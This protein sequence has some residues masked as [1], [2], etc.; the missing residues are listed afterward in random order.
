MALDR[1]DIQYAV[2]EAC[3]GMVSPTTGDRGKLKRIARYL[4]DKPSVVWA[5]DYQERQTTIFGY[6]D[7]DWAGCRMTATSTI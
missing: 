2:K 1:S 6:S 5:C 4:C 3:R 7:S